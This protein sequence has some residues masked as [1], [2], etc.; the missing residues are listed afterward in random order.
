MFKFSRTGWSIG[1][2]A[3]PINY[4]A[5]VGAHW[6]GSFVF[7]YRLEGD[8]IRWPK[9]DYGFACWSRISGFSTFGKLGG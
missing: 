8:G 5:G 6:D 4:A 1:I 2:P 7:A 9:G 3:T